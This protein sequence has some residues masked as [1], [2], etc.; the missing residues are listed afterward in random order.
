MNG[1]TQMQA[2]KKMYV[3]EGKKKLLSRLSSQSI[4]EISKKQSPESQ[5]NVEIFLFSNN[6]LNFTTL[7]AFTKNAV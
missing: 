2:G 3:T 4:D 7:S 1:E 5:S 6:R